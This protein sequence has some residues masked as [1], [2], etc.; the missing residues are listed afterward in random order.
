[1]TVELNNV[2]AQRMPFLPDEF[3]FYSIDDYECF[4]ERLLV[5]QRSS[6]ELIQAPGSE[7]VQDV[8]RQLCWSFWQARDDFP[9]AEL[10]NYIELVIRQM[11]V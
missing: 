2:R 3:H 11:G 4:E 1:V 6:T 8:L 5:T 10:H 7:L 9:T